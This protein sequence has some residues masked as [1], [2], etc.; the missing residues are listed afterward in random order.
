MYIAEVAPPTCGAA[1]PHC[2]N[3]PLRRGCSAPF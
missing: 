2:S 3:W 1:W